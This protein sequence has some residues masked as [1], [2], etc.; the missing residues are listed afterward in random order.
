[1]ETAP[2]RRNEMDEECEDREGGRRISELELDLRL[3]TSYKTFSSN[4]GLMGI[5]VT[6]PGVV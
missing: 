2:E 4:S 6:E 5:C 1:M 3:W